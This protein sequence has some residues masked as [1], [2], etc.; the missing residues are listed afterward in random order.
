MGKEERRD[1]EE[2]PRP[3]HHCIPHLSIFWAFRGESQHWSKQLLV[4]EAFSVVQLDS[5]PNQCCML[6]SAETG[7]F[8]KREEAAGST[9]WKLTLV[10]LPELSGTGSDSLGPA[11]PFPKSLD[12]S[13]TPCNLCVNL[14][15]SQWLMRAYKTGSRWNPPNTAPQKP[16]ET[17]LLSLITMKV[18]PASPSSFM[19]DPS[20][21]KQELGFHTH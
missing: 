20:A 11:C 19:W 7:L 3:V 6:L 17:W 14:F 12:S 5:L 21:W 10:R 16:H 8:F 18:L 4:E 13:V 15:C 9:S 2:L 1:R